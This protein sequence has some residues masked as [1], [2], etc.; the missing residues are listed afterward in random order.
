MIYKES[1]GYRTRLIRKK[2]AANKLFSIF[3][4]MEVYPDGISSRSAFAEVKYFWAAIE[5]IASSPTHTF[6]YVSRVVALII[7]HTRLESGDYNQFMAAISNYYHP[8]TLLSAPA[9][10]PKISQ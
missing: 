3:R 2:Y 5:Q 8:E 4:I 6:I 10:L 7:P 1:T 9:T